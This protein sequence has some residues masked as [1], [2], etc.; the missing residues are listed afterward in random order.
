MIVPTILRIATLL[1]FTGRA[2]QHLFWDAPL[3]TLLW[4][5]QWMEGIILFLRGGTWQEYVTSAQADHA[6]Q[7]ISLG[8]GI[9][10][11]LMAVFTL[12]VSE[13]QKGVTWLYII[14]S[15]AL[16]FLAFLYCKEK[17]FQ[18][19]QFFEYTIQ[20]L[21]PVVFI[22][23]VNGKIQRSRIELFLKIAIALTFSSHGLYAIGVYPRPGAFI[24]MVINILHTS[25]AGAIRFL[26][27]AGVLDFL[28]SIAIFIPRISRA[29]LI[30]AVIWGGLTA[31]AR[32]WA[33]FY[34]S[35]PLESL[36][37]HLYE[38]IYRLPHMLVP[39]AVLYLSFP[40]LSI[41]RIVRSRRSALDEHTIEVAN[42]MNE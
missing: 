42:Q 14:A 24:D 38:T 20:F 34:W 7:M 25:E 19:G 6:I 15:L 28:V 29:A 23:V 12:F 26:N 4:D 33:N 40:G 17:F 10:Y 41:F 2:W 9:F 18:L 13:K 8:F 36:H 31:L 1:L 21:L 30:Y 16:T 27:I 39:L 37:Q 35:F 11:S 32:V 22:Y 5:Q 3:R